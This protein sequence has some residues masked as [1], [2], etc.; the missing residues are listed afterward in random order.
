MIDHT[1]LK[2]GVS[3]V[4]E[5][6]QS[7]GTVMA[8]LWASIPLVVRCMTTCIL[9]HYSATSKW[10]FSNKRKKASNFTV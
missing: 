4:P 6:R 2:N 8:I 10:T 3:S 1:H 5:K 7:I 9:W